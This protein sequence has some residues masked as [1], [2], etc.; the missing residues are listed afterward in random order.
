MM[1]GEVI[2]SLLSNIWI[3]HIQSVWNFVLLWYFFP[4]AYHLTLAF[5]F[6]SL[7]YLTGFVYMGIFQLSYRPKFLPHSQR[8]HSPIFLSMVMDIRLVER[9]SNTRP[10]WELPNTVKWQKRARFNVSFVRG[11]SHFFRRLPV[12]ITCLRPRYLSSSSPD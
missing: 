3:F 1:R 10:L 6:F 9:N 11:R 5:R 12:A 8:R 4:L 2:V 7:K